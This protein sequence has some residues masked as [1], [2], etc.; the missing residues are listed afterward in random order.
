MRRLLWHRPV[1]AQGCREGRLG[2]YFGICLFVCIANQRSA[3]R[4]RSDGL[5]RAVAYLLAKMVE[6]ML[7]IVCLSLIVS[8]AIF[9]AVGF[10]GHFVLFWL[11]YF[12][13]IS[14]GM[15]GWWSPCVAASAQGKCTSHAW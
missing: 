7:V 5:Y 12:V 4:E 3:C 9:F 1:L 6:E 14:I 8:A 15:G 13:T 10:R 2:A 11:V